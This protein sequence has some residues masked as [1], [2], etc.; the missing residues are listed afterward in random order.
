[1]SGVNGQEGTMDEVG[2]EACTDPETMLP[3]LV[4]AGERKLRLLT[5]ACLRRLWPL[6]PDGPSR[7]AVEVGEAWAD[8]LAGRQDLDAAFDAAVDFGVVPAEDPALPQAAAEAVQGAAAVFPDYGAALHA[9]G[10]WAARQ[11]RGNE[12]RAT[13]A[14]LVRCVFGPL[15]FRGVARDP[16]WLTAEVLS[17]AQAAYEERALPSG[18]LEPARLA[19]LA[20]ALEDA[21]C[22]DAHVL[23]YLR[24]PGPHVRGCW[25]VDLIL[26]KS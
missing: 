16:A 1:M 4:E 14:R 15:P 13:L 6:L 7:Q 3:L 21:G 11:G 17:L 22:A 12:E 5:C 8:G 10:E 19:L 24:G 26:G 2:W 23:R 20:D 25:P 9:A 18:G